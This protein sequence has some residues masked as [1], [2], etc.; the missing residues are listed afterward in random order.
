MGRVRAASAALFVV[1]VLGTPAT[2][3]SLSDTLIKAYLNNPS[4]EVSRA[5][6]RGA[7]ESVA[8]A[9]AGLRPVVTANG[10]FVFEDSSDGLGASNAGSASLDGSVTVFDGGAT[11]AAVDGAKAGVEAARALL[12]ATEQDVLLEAV[13]AYSD[14]LQDIR[15][16]ELERTTLRVFMQELQ[17]ARDRF[18]VGEV[19]RTDVSQA[20]AVVAS[21]RSSLAAAIGSLAISREAYLSVV[22]EPPGELSPP[23]PLPPLPATRDEAV[24][25]AMREHPSIRAAR[26]N[27]LAANFAVDSARAAFRPTIDIIGSVGVD[28]TSSEISGIFGSGRVN[29]TETSASVGVTASV[30]I[31]TGGVLSS[32]V[33]EAIALVEQTKA[34]LHDT[35]RLIRQAVGESYASLEVA[36]ASIVA[37]R[38]AIRAARIA[39]EGV[40]EEALLGAR[41]TLDVLDAETE[42]LEAQTTL[43]SAERD[44]DVAAYALLS[45]MGKLTVDHLGLNVAEYDPNVNFN[46]VQ[47]GPPGRFDGS[48][49]DRIRR[50]FGRTD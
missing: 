26:F 22:G 13:T 28:R 14:V 20:E 25:I 8:Q 6:V 45:A 44:E 15:I 10:S 21:S 7:D 5:T 24:A 46:R 11:F 4:L 12:V 9:R 38:E 42:L 39:F 17:A 32:G 1:C 48:V 49:V 36:R 19:T 27:E 18:E 29:D 40:R 16:V 35:A 34:E 43:A 37:S 50:R 2:A 41:T 33:R 47:S 23:P 3:Q 30:P 31:I